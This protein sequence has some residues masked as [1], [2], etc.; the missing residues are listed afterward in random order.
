MEKW[1]TGV[2]GLANVD[3]VVRGSH[4][5]ETDRCAPGEAE[6]EKP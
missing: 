3:E 2:Q 6:E 4:T 1:R 5:K